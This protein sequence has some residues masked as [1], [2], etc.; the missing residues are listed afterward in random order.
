MEAIPAGRLLIEPRVGCAD[1]R[2]LFILL[3][4]VTSLVCRPRRSPA[5]YFSISGCD[6]FIH[7][8]L[9]LYTTLTLTVTFR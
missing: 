6:G 1:H 3:S 8:T 7:F 2:M 5:W 4:V 9:M